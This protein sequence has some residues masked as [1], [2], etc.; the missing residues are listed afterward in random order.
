MSLKTLIAALG[1]STLAMAAQGAVVVQPFTV[2]EGAIPGTTSHQVTADQITLRYEASVVQTVNEGVITFTETGW[3]DATGFVMGSTAQTSFLNGPE[4]TGYGLYGL[5]EV[6]GTISFAGTTA[7]A[8]FTSGNVSLFAD[9]TN[10]TVLSVI[11]GGTQTVNDVAGDDS[12]LASSNAV[13]AGSQANIPLV[14]NQ[15]AAGGSYVLNYGD[16]VLTTLGEQYFI[17]PINFYMNVT[18]TGENESFTPPLTGGAY[19]GR[20]V[21][22][23]SAG[24]FSVPEPAS[25]TLLGLGLLGLGL[26][27]R[28]RSA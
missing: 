11:A 27:S 2:Q 12:L 21:G 6:T 20:L 26:S 5:F 3:F 4:P 7:L 24:F 28:R 25:L 14:G 23:G 8:T 19:T 22:D 15:A 13:L 10:D 9:P 18:V 1:L 17:D 16:L